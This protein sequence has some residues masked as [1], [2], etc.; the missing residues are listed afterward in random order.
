MATNIDQRDSLLEELADQGL[1]PVS[2]KQGK[3]L[4]R[5]TGAAAYVECSASVDIQGIEK[6]FKTAVRVA[7]NRSDWLVEDR[8][9]LKEDMKHNT[10]WKR[11]KLI[12][13]GHGRSGKVRKRLLSL[14]YSCL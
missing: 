9:Q 2:E 3:Q 12:T 5:R 1:A 13:L 10:V 4:A 14:N 6:L 7:L 11:L 8:K